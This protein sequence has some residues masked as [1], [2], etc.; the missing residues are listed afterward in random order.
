M[1]R[2]IPESNILEK[3]VELEEDISTKMIDKCKC[4]IV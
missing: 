3:P 4:G 2:K 1:A